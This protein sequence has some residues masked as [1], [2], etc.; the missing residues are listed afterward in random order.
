[1]LLHPRQETDRLA[2]E[3]KSSWLTP[4]LVLSVTLILSLIVS[5]FLEGRAAAMGE[6]S[7]PEEWEWWTAEMQNNYMQAMQVTQDQPSCT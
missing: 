4:M 6:V 5:G 1:M 3:N 7:L 2:E